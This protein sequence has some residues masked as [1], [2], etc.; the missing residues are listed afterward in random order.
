ML[1]ANK[2]IR[3]VV[4]TR[5]KENVFMLTPKCYAWRWGERL[6]VIVSAKTRNFKNAG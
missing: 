2:F 3:S 1:Q 6:V 4:R 5:L